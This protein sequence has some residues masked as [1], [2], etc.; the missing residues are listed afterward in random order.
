MLLNVA[1]VLEAAADDVVADGSMAKKRVIDGG[2][3]IVVDHRLISRVDRL[4]FWIVTSTVGRHND[5]DDGGDEL[6]CILS[7]QLAVSTV[8][9]TVFGEPKQ[10]NKQTNKNRNERK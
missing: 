3:N 1:G 6:S 8:M 4:F 2:V 9:A 10:T 7:K 5:D